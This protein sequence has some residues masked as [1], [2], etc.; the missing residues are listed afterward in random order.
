MSIILRNVRG[1][2]GLT[3]L[4]RRNG[5]VVAS[6]G[7]CTVSLVPKLMLI[8]FAVVMLFAIVMAM[9]S[10]G[11]SAP[12]PSESLM[13]LPVIGNLAVK[14]KEKEDQLGAKQK[15]LHDVFDAAGT[16]VDFTKPA[17]LTLVGAK[18]SKEVV[19]KV[20]AMD[21][22][23]ADLGKERD[24]LAELKRISDDNEQRRR[25]PA[26]TL[27]FPGPDDREK[28]KSLGEIVVAS[29][30]FKEA[31][32]SLGLPQE[33]QKALVRQGI[34]SMEKGFGLPELKATFLTGAGWGPEST[35]VPGLVIDKATRP[36]QV[37]DI[38]P[39]ANT[40]MAAVKYMEETTRT[41]AA[42]ERNEN[43]S[44]AESSFELT[45]QSETVRSVGESVPVTDEQL[46][47]VQGAQ[48][49]LEQRLGFGVRQRVDG[50]VIIGDGNTP[51]LRGI[52]NK[53][54]IQTQA[55]G[56]DPIPDAIYKA[57]TLVRVTG[58]AFP[59]A[60]VIHP[61]NW[62]AVRLMRTADG[63]YI[64]GSPAE[65]GPDRIWGI[66]AVQC[67]ADAAGTAYVGDYANFCALYERRGL[68]VA[69]GYVNN[70]FLQGRR[71]IRAGLRVAFVIY[72]AAAFC[73]VTGL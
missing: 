61:T 19:E 46:E 32:A 41:H 11:L 12:A 16:D 37:L 6:G 60:V 44:Y 52:K 34:A 63:I 18:D 35:R 25:Q 17:V 4:M 73:S 27:P 72:R 1:I 68:E 42:A 64:W 5:S 28:R 67:D 70:D 53:V 65:T 14:L 48:S 40:G 66:Q 57:M 45:E 51:N 29:A 13:A 10:G 36:I 69:I 33:E 22:E 59:N 9:F 71:T 49:Y 55:K 8:A 62:Q 31:R 47:D 3:A 20:R 2:S 54:G 43:A 21:K 7:T 26:K 24:D 39:S 23:L 56:A 50:Q 30:A 15:A 38:I 58:R